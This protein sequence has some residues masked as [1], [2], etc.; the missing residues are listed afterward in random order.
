M[1]RIFNFS[2]GPA[3]LPAEAAAW[4]RPTACPV[5]SRELNVSFTSIGVGV[6]SSTEGSTNIRPEIHRT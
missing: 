5:A 2:A 4:T 6:P 3:M 1:S